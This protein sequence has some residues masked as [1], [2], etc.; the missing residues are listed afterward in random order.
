MPRKKTKVHIFVF[1]SNLAGRHG[2]GAAKDAH[3]L[4][5]AVYGRGIGRQGRSYAIPTKD[6]NIQTLPLER[7]QV[8]ITQFIDYARRHPELLFDV[9]RIGCGHA[10]YTDQR[11]S[12]LFKGAPKNVQLPTGWRLMWQEGM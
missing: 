8:Y 11:I 9:T 12:P 6:E 4:Y 2:L 10:G 3:R 5:G 7:I 1:G